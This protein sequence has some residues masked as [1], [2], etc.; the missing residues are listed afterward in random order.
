M[1]RL[2][3]AVKAWDH[4]WGDRYGD[5]ALEEMGEEVKV[6]LAAADGHDLAHGL[7]RIRIDD[8]T[9]ERAAKSLAGVPIDQP[10]PQW[11][12]AS[13]DRWREQTRKALAAAVQEER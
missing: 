8:A 9:L 6:A 11:Y 13:V 12:T 5:E 1:S 4:Y 3:A 2:E 7:H 10:W